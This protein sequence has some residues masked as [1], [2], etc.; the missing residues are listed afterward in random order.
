MIIEDF[1]TY[2]SSASYECFR[3]AQEFVKNKLPVE[4]KYHVHLNQSCDTHADDENDLYPE[5]DGKELSLLNW[6]EVVD[7]L[8][9]KGKVPEW[10][11]ISV[12]AEGKDF[13][14]LRLLCCGRYTGER[15]KM[16]YSN[17]GQGPFGIKSPDLPS[18]YS[19]GKKFKIG[20]V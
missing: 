13:T 18:N 3:F 16:Y 5:D 8:V 11:D 2:L 6:K 19:E 15:K 9:R 14:L 12:F 10:I 7:L 4:F 20:K 17:R 1:H